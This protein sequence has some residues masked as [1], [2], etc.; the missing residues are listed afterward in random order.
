M[1]D[2]PALT[3]SARR[4]ADAFANYPAPQRM[5]AFLEGVRAFHRHAPSHVTDGQQAAGVADDDGGAV[6]A[7]LH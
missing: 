5:A 3:A 2:D 4:V 1:L 7:N 6:R